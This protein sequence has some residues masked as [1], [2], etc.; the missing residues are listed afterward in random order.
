M[1]NPQIRLIRGDAIYGTSI[2]RLYDNP[3]LD[4]TLRP[5]DKVIVQPDERYFLS[6]GLRATNPCS[7]SPATRSPPSTP[8]PS[9]GA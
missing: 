8:C 7:P 6:L 1:N 9:W 5:G 3:A 4:T 2:D